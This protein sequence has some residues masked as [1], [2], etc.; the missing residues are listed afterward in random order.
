MDYIRTNIKEY[1]NVD[2]VQLIKAAGA[3]GGIHFI[4]QTI[5][6]IS[7]LLFIRYILYNSKYGFHLS[8]L[9]A[10]ISG[11]TVDL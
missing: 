7:L 9:Q 10:L 1:Y 11:F 2:F 8:P 6:Q 3:K 5:G 4:V